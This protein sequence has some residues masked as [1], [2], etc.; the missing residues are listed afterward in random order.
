MFGVEPFRRAIQSILLKLHGIPEVLAAR[1][2]L[3][4]CEFSDDVLPDGGQRLRLRVPEPHSCKDGG[5]FKVEVVPWGVRVLAPL[6]TEVDAG[7][8]LVRALVLR[9]PPVA[10]YAKERAVRRYEVPTEPLEVRGEVFNEAERGVFD[11]G[12]VSVLVLGKPFAVV[13]VRQLR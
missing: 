9:K 6:V 10:V 12:F 4:H 8:R 5:G 3:P 1:G 11:V 13:V 7:V 2:P